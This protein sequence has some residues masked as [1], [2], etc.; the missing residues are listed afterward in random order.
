MSF[1]LQERIVEATLK[2]IRK[3]DFFGCRIGSLTWDEGSANTLQML[4]AMNVVKKEDVL[5][6][7]HE[8]LLEIGRES[9]NEHIKFFKT[10]K[11]Y[12]DHTYSPEALAYAMRE[13]EITI[14]EVAKIK[15]DH[16]ENPITFV[17]HT[18]KGKENFLAMMF[19]EL[20]GYK[21]RPV[22]AHKGPLPI[23]VEH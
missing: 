21:K 5:N 7:I 4:V 12:P 2:E 11:I 17:E 8:R 3:V 13:G 1:I 14:G 10:E 9:F 6:T 19:D 15:F 23:C 18:L 22:L 20:I 16:A